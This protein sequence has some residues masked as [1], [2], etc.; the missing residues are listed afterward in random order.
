MTEMEVEFVPEDFGKT[1]QLYVDWDDIPHGDHVY[2]SGYLRSV[3]LHEGWQGGEFVNGET[4]ILDADFVAR[5]EAA[6]KSPFSVIL[7]P[8]SCILSVVEDE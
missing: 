7:V 6:M 8:S 5:V 3:F 1:Y 2:F 4:Y